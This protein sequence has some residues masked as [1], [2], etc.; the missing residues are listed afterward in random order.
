MD[1]LARFELRVTAR[2]KPTD[3]R[4]WNGG[5]MASN[6][7][8]VALMAGVDAFRQALAER[9]FEVAHMGYGVTATEAEDAGLVTP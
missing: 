4:R 3:K 7:A 5:P 2:D 6:E 1:Q 8:S 9:G